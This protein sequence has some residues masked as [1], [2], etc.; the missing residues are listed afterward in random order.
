MGKVYVVGNFKGGVGKTKAVTMLSYV[1]AVNR[2]LKT[3]V[4]DLDPQGNATRVLAKTGNLSEIS[5]TITEGFESGDLRNSITHILPNLD[6]IGANTAFR[7]LTKI[8]ISKFP[9]DEDKQITY[10][11]ELLKP[12]RDEYDA[13]YIDVPPTISD[14]SDNA[15]LAADYCII[16]LQTQELSLDGAQTYIAYMQYLADAY[17]NRLQVLGIIPCMLKPGGRVDNKVLQQARDLYGGNILDTIVKYQERLKVYDVEGIH[18]G[19][20]YSGTQD[21]WDVKAHQVFIDVLNELETHKR[22]LE[23]GK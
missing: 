15:M 23:G 3:L 9:E 6:L 18:M 22:V 12:L 13:I 11:N 14:Y 7:N 21:G 10:L 8:L 5:A 17:N 1:S 19:T 16:V 4:I 20:N 2:H